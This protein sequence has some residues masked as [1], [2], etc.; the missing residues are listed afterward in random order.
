MNCNNIN[1][2][3]NNDGFNEA[4]RIIAEAQRNHPLGTCCLPNN[5]SCVAGPTGTTSKD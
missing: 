3:N 5:N 1:N 4:R 2:D